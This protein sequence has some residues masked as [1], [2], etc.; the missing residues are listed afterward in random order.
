[1]GKGYVFAVHTEPQGTV[2]PR[3]REGMGRRPALALNGIVV[4]IYG[5]TH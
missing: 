2:S 1:M 5:R 4:G 3:N